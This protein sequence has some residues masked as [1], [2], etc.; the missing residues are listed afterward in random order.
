MPSL[1]PSDTMHAFIVAVKHRMEEQHITLTRLAA[2]TGRD[3]AGLH[4]SINGQG[5]S[6]TF[7]TAD[8]IAEALGTTTLELI[9]SGMNQLHEST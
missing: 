2:V 4:R 9:Q 6:C 3:R 1:A 5:G 7:A 8:A